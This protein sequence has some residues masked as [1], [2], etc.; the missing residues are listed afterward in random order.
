MLALRDRLSA[1]LAGRVN[2]VLGL[3]SLDDFGRGDAQLGHLVGVH[4]HPHCVL[5]AEHLHARHTFDAGELVLQVDDGVVGEELLAQFAA[6]RVDRDQHQRRGKR[7]LHGEA[8][9]GDLCRQL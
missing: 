6:G 5:S 3:D 9:G 2:V 7:L 1:D 4:P 8:G